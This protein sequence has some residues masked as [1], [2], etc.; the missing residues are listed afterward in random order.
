MIDKAG[1]VRAR[2]CEVRLGESKSKGTPF[3]GVMFAV[4]EGPFTGQRVKWEG[5]L[6]ERTAER[7]IE[8]LQHCGWD[9]DDISV[10]AT[11]LNGLDRNDVDLVIAMEPYNGDDPSK[12]GNMYPKVQ[13]VNRVGTGPKFAGE[14]VGAAKAVEFGQKF[15]GLALAVKAK[16]GAQSPPPPKD[17]PK[18]PF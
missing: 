11:G 6:T 1:T 7:T 9:G 16:A 18:L 8:S 10:F 13:W 2:A 4:V 12:A 3:V 15:R 17:D 5:W 14:S